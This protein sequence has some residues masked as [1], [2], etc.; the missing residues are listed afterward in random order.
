MDYNVIVICDDDSL[1]NCKITQIETI[2][3][4]T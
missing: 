4:Q 3:K 1:I 2:G